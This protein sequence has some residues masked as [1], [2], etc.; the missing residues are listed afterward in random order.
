MI[1]YVVQKCKEILQNKKNFG[2]EIFWIMNVFLS[3]WNL[4]SYQSGILQCSQES[5]YFSSC[6]DLIINHSK[7]PFMTA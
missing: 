7:N 6:S 5:Q 4:F 3:L 2:H 1:C